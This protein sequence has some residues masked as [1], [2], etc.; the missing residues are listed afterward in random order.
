[1]IE[2]FKYI[3]ELDAF[4]CTKEYMEIAEQ[5]GICEWT[6]VVWIGRLFIL[7]NDYGEHWHDNW[8]EREEIEE[9]AKELGYCS[10]ELLI[11]VPTVFQNGKDGPCHSDGMRK[12]FWTDVM[13]SL[14]LSL[15]T[16]IEEARKNNEYNKGD[17]DYIENLEERIG[18][19]RK[20][21]G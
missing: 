21:Y 9:K 13:K 20:K 11:V 1:M 17:M 15:D 8:D 2:I 10:S 19:M 18:E 3:P 5:L 14:K 16:I 4:T 12:M 7:D 6:P